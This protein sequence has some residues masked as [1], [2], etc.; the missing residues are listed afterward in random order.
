ML[1]AEGHN[2]TNYPSIPQVIVNNY[3][4]NDN[5]LHVNLEDIS[6]RQYNMLNDEQKNIVDKILEIS[7]VIDY[8]G[9]R[10][11]YIDRPGGSEKTFVYTTL[12]NLLKS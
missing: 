10:C 7:N 9:S 8:N 6:N 1:I 2:I 4:E 3:L 11:F 12:Y 5:E